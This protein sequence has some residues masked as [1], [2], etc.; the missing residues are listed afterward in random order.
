MVNFFRQDHLIWAPQVLK[1]EARKY[2]ALA[3]SGVGSPAQAMPM[4]HEMS[5]Q[6]ERSPK[7]SNVSGP[8]IW[9]GSLDTPDPI[10]YQTRLA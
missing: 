6:L 7:S 10:D 5:T 3:V 9:S 4:A 2:T 1:L 8:S